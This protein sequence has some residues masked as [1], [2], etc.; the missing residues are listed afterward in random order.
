MKVRDVM[1]GFVQMI[2]VNE[3]RNF[4]KKKVWWWFVRDHK[5]KTNID[6]AR[7]SLHVKVSAYV[8]RWPPP[9]H[10]VSEK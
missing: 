4:N 8:L 9:Q 6:C 7:C 5:T 2:D 3:D 10:P 1:V